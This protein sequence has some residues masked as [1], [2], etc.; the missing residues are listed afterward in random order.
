MNKPSLRHDV[1]SR[2][3][4]KR[5]M[6]MCLL[7]AL[8]VYLVFLAI[9]TV[10]GMSMIEMLRDPAQQTGQSS[11][12]GFISSI[13]TWLWL[14]AGLF[15][16]FRLAAVPDTQNA[17]HMTL[18]KLACGF[19]VFLAVDD[20][21]LIHDRYITEGILI[22]AYALFLA[23]LIKRFW[24]LITDIDG[25]AFLLAGAMLFMSVLVDATQEI[26]PVSYGASQALEEGFK[27]LG[28]A[29]WAY[30][31]FRIAAWRLRA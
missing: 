30:F 20:F 24:G 17:A 16:F 27:F 12:L 5:C 23:Y 11:F 25:A 15:C 21:F 22:P 26:L 29:G 18:L 28:A 4:I 3:A 14:A 19:S 1:L 31:C 10:G 9:G 6:K 8:G 2:A 13:G 7:P